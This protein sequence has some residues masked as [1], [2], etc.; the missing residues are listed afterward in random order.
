MKKSIVLAALVFVL[1]LVMSS[2]GSAPQKKSKIDL[3]PDFAKG[4]KYWPA[5]KICAAYGQDTTPESVNTDIDD[6]TQSGRVELAREMKVVVNAIHKDYRRKIKAKGGRDDE[7]ATVDASIGQTIDTLVAGSE[8][9]DADTTLNG[10]VDMVWVLVCIDHEKFINAI[11]NAQDIDEA[12]KEEIMQ[13]ATNEW[14]ELLK[15]SEINK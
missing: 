4:S 12:L 10:D 2:C 9:I 6:A 11:K 3:G 15:K 13:R 1:A 14:D 5:N 7:S 8:R